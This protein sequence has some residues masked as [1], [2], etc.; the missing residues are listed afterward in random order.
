MYD[1]KYQVFISSTYID[2]IDARNK[3][4]DAIL[5]MYHFPVGMEL[6]GAANEEQWQI[7]SETIDSS[8]Y[9]VLIIGQRYGTIIP[10]GMP[11]SGI[12][13]TEKEF[14][15]ALKKKIPILAFIID[16]NVPVKPEYVEKEHL[17]QFALFKSTVKDGRLIERWS[18]TDELAQKVTNALYKQISRTKRPGW[19]R[20]DS[21]DIEKSLSE[22]VELS[23]QNRDLQEEN[24]KLCIELEKLRSSPIREPLLT[25]SVEK[26]TPISDIEKESDFYHHNNLINIDE[27]GVV[28]LKLKTITTKG[29][30]ID[31]S[32]KSIYDIPIEYRNYISDQEIDEYN[33]KLPSKQIIDDYY[34]DYLNYLRL[35][36]NG[37]AITIYVNNIGTAKA[38]DVSVSI[39]FPKEVKVYSVEDTIDVSEPEAPEKPDDLIMKAHYRANQNKNAVDIALAQLDIMD[40]LKKNYELPVYSS[41]ISALTNNNVFES[42]YVNENEVVIEQKRGIVHTK[43]E[44]FR[45]CI[46]IPTT[47]GEYEA[48]ITFMCAEYERPKESTIKIIVEEKIEK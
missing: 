11:D 8:D 20:G 6:F 31:Y 13:Y 7:I 33:R 35:I 46:L 41:P 4:R 24:K 14:R 21:V 37:I 40:C 5:S 18:S 47:I 36:E 19:I 10:D 23:K 29:K 2:L 1:K 28:Y 42:I 38:T 39:T 15:Y 17:E 44:W 32:P 25:L 3:V 48:K 22:I 12:S 26:S 30:E 43:S 45:G 27:E 16:D 9:Y 34:L